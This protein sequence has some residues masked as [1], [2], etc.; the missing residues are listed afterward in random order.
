MTGSSSTTVNVAL[1]ARSY[2]IHIGDGLIADAAQWITPLLQRPQ[3]AIVTDENVA[4]HHLAPLSKAL[5]QAG[6]STVPIIL[7][8]GEQTKSFEE[9]ERLVRALL[10][11]DVERGDMIIALGGGVV[12][13][14]TGFAASIL[15][16][17]IDFIQ[18]PTTLLAQVD[19]SVGGKTGINTP[20]GK[21]LAGTFHQPRLVI[22]DTNALDTLP[23]RQLK[24]GYAEVVKY[25]LINDA[26]FFEWLEQN[27]TAVIGGDPVARRHAV[28][29]SCAAKAAIVATDERES[30]ARALLNLGHTFGHALEAA[31]GYGERLLHGEA[32]SIGLVLAFELS[33]ALGLSSNGAQ[34]VADHLKAV[35]LPTRLAHIPGGPPN[36]DEIMGLIQQDKKVSA[37]KPTFI[38]ARGIGQAYVAR[39]ID[40]ST[41]RK[42]LMEAQA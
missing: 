24:A 37:G 1:D 2:D 9:L 16:R 6:I 31:T 40:L 4:R 39:D 33:H 14:I 22:A 12:G 28:V 23:E 29:T 18:I 32:V 8:P 26:D 30:G 34:R 27:G 11:A 42:I 38:L 25:G 19:S 7:P 41:V 10:Q 3:A 13:D 20:E 21:N 5:D 15:R 36:V 17:G 35:G